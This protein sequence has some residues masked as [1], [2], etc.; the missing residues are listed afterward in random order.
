MAHLSIIIII[1]IICK[2]WL[3]FSVGPPPT[4]L[5]N[6]WIDTVNIFTQS[7]SILVPPCNVS[8]RFLMLLYR[9]IITGGERVNT[10]K[11]KYLYLYLYLNSDQDIL[12]WNFKSS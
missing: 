6:I 1:I 7:S 11:F 10:L 12:L 3:E 2:N 8:R 9:C 5:L 4:N